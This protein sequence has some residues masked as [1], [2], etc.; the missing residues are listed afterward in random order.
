MTTE[1]IKRE[2]NEGESSALQH[3][4]N[5]IDGDGYDVLLT[6]SI[7]VLFTL[8]VLFCVPF[9]LYLIVTVIN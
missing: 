5:F 7:K 8:I 1:V 3:L 6:K 9:F 4:L 2:Q